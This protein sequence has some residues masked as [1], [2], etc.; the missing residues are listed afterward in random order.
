VTKVWSAVRSTKSVAIGAAT[1]L[2]LLTPGSGCKAWADGPLAAK[3][4]LTTLQSYTGGPLQRP[5][6]IL[7]YD[8]VADTDVQVDKSLKLRPRHVLTGDEKPDAIA[9][10]SQSTF[11]DELA[12]KLAKTGIPVEHVSSDTAPS[13]NSLVVQ[14]SFASLHQGDKTQRTTVG[15]GLGS[16]EV[17]TKIDVRVKTSSDAVLLSQFQTET[18]TAKNIGAAAPVAAGMSPAAVATKSVVTDRR[19][20]LNHYVSETADASAK[21]ITRLMA[22]QGWIKLN[23]KGDVVP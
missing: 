2:L 19:K 11:S 10:K 23:D 22:D 8:L 18:T 12:K 21:E 7:I 3:V 5:N 14:G 1:T 20:T 16:A 13:D 4:K 15:M 17:Q 9:K 6:K